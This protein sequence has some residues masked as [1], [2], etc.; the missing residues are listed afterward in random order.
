MCSNNLTR[1]YGHNKIILFFF[2]L[3]C[4]NKIHWF[5]VLYRFINTAFVLEETR[6]WSAFSIHFKYILLRYNENL[7]PLHIILI[8]LVSYNL[9]L[10]FCDFIVQKANFSKKKQE[11]IFKRIMK[12]DI[13]VYILVTFLHK[14]YLPFW[15]FMHF[16]NYDGKWDLRSKLCLQRSWNGQWWS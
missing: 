13:C 16:L 8:R 3:S 5:V 12:A 14:Y 7:V 4:W 15:M 1:Y 6:W 10:F 9:I 2:M 11:N